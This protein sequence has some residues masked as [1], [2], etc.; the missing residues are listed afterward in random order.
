MLKNVIDTKIFS[1]G[2]YCCFHSLIYH[3]ITQN[4]QSAIMRV[5][6]KMVF[7]SHESFVFF[8]FES[9][10]LKSLKYLQSRQKFEL[11]ISN[12]IWPH[13]FRSGVL[14]YNFHVWLVYYF[15]LYAAIFQFLWIWEG[16][17]FHHIKYTI[18]TLSPLMDPGTCT[19]VW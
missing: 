1:S 14:S 13:V 18:A 6:N 15:F 8:T 10:Y 19:I 11:K 9:I 12:N 16:V 17:V 3:Y 2:L 4:C 7:I 5:K